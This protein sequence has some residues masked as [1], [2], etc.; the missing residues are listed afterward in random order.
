MSLPFLIYCSLLRKAQYRSLRDL[1]TV[2]NGTVDM[3][4]IEKAMRDAV[5]K[6]LMLSQE[7]LIF[8]EELLRSGEGSEIMERNVVSRAYYSAHHAVRALLLFEE[9]GDVDGHREAIEATYDILKRNPAA[10][11]L[12]GTG[13]AEQFR[14]DF[15]RLL[16]RRHLADYYPY[17]T[18]ASNEAPL[19]FSLAAQEAIQFARRVIE[20]TKEYITLKEEGKI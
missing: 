1:N 20:K 19:D 9:R 12:L 16:E 8:S 6:R 3:I 10:R 14:K 4:A 11:T 2:Q 5:T 13:N 18:N 15:G 17:G 7:F